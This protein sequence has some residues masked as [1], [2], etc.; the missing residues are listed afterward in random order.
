[1]RF[2]WRRREAEQTIDMTTEQAQREHAELLRLE[3]AAKPRRIVD[4]SRPPIPQEPQGVTRWRDLPYDHPSRLGF[5]VV[6]KQPAPPPPWSR[7]LPDIVD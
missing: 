6:R 7:A 1:M 3:D 4:F 5:Q 2:P